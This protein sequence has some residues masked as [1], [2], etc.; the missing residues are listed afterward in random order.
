MLLVNRVEFENYVALVSLAMERPVHGAPKTTAIASLV[1]KL[2]IQA[3]Q[4]RIG[5]PRKQA[6]PRSRLRSPSPSCESESP[7][8]VHCAFG[9]SVDHAPTTMPPFQTVI[10]DTLEG[11]RADATENFDAA[12]PL[13]EATAASSSLSDLS[14]AVFLESL[15]TLE[16]APSDGLTSNMLDASLPDS[17]SDGT[18]EINSIMNSILPGSHGSDYAESAFLKNDLVYSVPSDLRWWNL[19]WSLPGKDGKLFDTDLSQNH[20]EVLKSESE[21]FSHTTPAASGGIPETTPLSAGEP[22]STGACC[23]T[24]PQPN[25]KDTAAHHTLDKV[26]CVPNPSGPGCSCLCESD[27]ALLSL[28]HSL[29]NGPLALGR[30]EAREPSQATASSSL[31]F[32]LSMSQAITR[33][34]A[35]S[36]DCPTCKKDP[37]YEV[38]AGLLISTALQIYARALKVF[39]EVLVSNGSTG[40]GCTVSSP[41]KQ[42]PCGDPRR[43]QKSLHSEEASVEVRIGDFLPTPKNARKIALYAMKLE[44]LDLERA[45][46]HVQTV[47][48]QSL[49]P[50]PAVEPP[51]LPEGSCCAKKHTEPKLPKRTTPLRLNPID[52]LIIRKLHIQLGEVLKTVENL[53]ANENQ[54]VL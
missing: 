45:L 26:H 41:C 34:C 28:Q 43:T 29:R 46:A 6:E 37:S 54:P 1:R 5:R 39:Q 42:C 25:V 40:C 44:L 24:Q 13:K 53:E 18:S 49:P 22:T 32:T 52:Q 51:P 4:S 48:Q 20:A 21:Q 23:S 12:L 17:K 9:A 27:V 14:L 15:Y 7:R 8:K 3:T 11:T 2:L 47:A 10:P 31:V 50:P 16:I 30:Q 38:S 33:K 35:C 19:A 36:A